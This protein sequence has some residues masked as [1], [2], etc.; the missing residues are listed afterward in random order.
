MFSYLSFSQT[1][2]GVKDLEDDGTQI[3]GRVRAEN[4]SSTVSRNPLF[5]KRITSAWTGKTLK[6]FQQGKARKSRILKEGLRHPAVQ[7]EKSW[8]RIIIV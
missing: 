6:E 5:S 4:S 3:S 1:S 7:K 8:T 2:P